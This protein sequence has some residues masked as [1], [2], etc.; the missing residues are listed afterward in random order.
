LKKQTAAHV[1][2]VAAESGEKRR[3]DAGATGYFAQAPPVLAAS[4]N[5]WTDAVGISKSWARGWAS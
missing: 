1:D 4:I 3:Q 2:K 5:F